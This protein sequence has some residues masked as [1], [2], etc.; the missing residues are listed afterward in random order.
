MNCEKCK[1]CIEVDCSNASNGYDSYC[2]C[3]YGLGDSYNDGYCN[4]PLIFIPIGILISKIK[5]LFRI[6]KANKTEWR[7][8]EMIETIERR[9]C[10]VCKREVKHFSGSL[11]LDYLDSDYIGYG[12]P[13]KIERKEICINCC[14]ELEEVVTK[15]LKEMEK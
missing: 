5:T 4:Y 3:K 12:N 7:K 1:Y 10:D 14:R 8:N 9:I 15:A 2:Y 11:V 13:V 6:I